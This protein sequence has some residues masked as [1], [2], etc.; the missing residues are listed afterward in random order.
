L[1]DRISA[2]AVLRE[3]QLFSGISADE[4]QRFEQTVEKLTRALTDQATL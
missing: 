4:L 3:T 1:F 2:S